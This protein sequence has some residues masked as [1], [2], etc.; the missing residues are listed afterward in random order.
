MTENLASD[1]LAI[2]IQQR[3]FYVVVACLTIFS[4]F[5]GSKFDGKER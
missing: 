2:N 1:N 5:R 4:Y 3:N